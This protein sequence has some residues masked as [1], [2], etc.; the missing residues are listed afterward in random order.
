MAQSFCIQLDMDCFPGREPRAVSTEHGF[1]SLYRI[2]L[3]GPAAATI[4]AANWNYNSLPCQPSANYGAWLLRVWAEGSKGEWAVRACRQR[5]ISRTKSITTNN[6]SQARI[7][8]RKA[9]QNGASSRASRLTGGR[10]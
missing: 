8:A 6:K 1:R 7:R 9:L 3:I 5:R 10:G 2:A 4:L